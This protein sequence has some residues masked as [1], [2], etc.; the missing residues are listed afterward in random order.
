MRKQKKKTFSLLQF[1]GSVENWKSLGGIF[2][3]LTYIV[4]TSRQKHFENCLN[5]RHRKWRGFGTTWRH[6][7][8][9]PNLINFFWQ[10]HWAFYFLRSSLFKTFYLQASFSFAPSTRFA[11]P[12]F[13]LILFASNLLQQ[14][15][16]SESPRALKRFRAIKYF[17]MDVSMEFD[18][19]KLSTMNFWWTVDENQLF[20]FIAAQFPAFV[21]RDLLRKR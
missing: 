13:A 2:I 1:H 4:I 10:A 7:L 19:L 9:F 17:L 16:N 21:L 12:R 20:F 11:S 8:I 15:S 6:F 3:P 14:V 5:C 18:L